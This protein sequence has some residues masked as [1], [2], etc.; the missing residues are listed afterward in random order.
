MAG[1]LRTLSLGVLGCGA[2]LAGVWVVPAAQDYLA[3]QAAGAKLPPVV[4]ALGEHAVH[5]GLLRDL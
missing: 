5:P 4:G 1:C 2:I 3:W